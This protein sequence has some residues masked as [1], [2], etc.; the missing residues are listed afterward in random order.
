MLV[1]HPDFADLALS[2][3]A[4][5]GIGRV[6]RFD[7]APMPPPPERGSETR[8]AT[9]AATAAG[10][11]CGQSPVAAADPL[12]LVYT[13]GTTGRPKGAVMTHAGMVWAS[14]TMATAWITATATSG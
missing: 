7:T 5:L 9:A 11:V 12:L 4:R 2:L 14:A 6:W 1:A 8:A 10:T 13:S 3:A